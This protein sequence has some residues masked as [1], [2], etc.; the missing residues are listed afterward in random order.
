MPDTR[1]TERAVKFAGATL[2]VSTCVYVM[3]ELSV[4]GAQ[5]A[6]A[7]PFLLALGIPALVSG[8]LMLGARRVRPVRLGL[9]IVLAAMF[10][11][12]SPA[13]TLIGML[14]VVAGA[15]GGLAGRFQRGPL[16]VASL[17]GALVV[18][19]FTCQV[20]L[21]LG[22]VSAGAALLWIGV[23]YLVMQGSA[24]ALGLLGPRDTLTDMLNPFFRLLAESVNVITA[25]L[26]V[27][28][29]GGQAWLQTTMLLLTLLAAQMALIHLARTRGALGRSR[30]D[31]ASRLSELET[32][33]SIGSEIL[34]TLDPVRLCSILEREC[35]R[36][37]DW[38]D[39]YIGLSYQT[40]PHQGLVYRRTR[41]AEA[42]VAERL[43]GNG[44]LN[45]ISGERSGVRLDSIAKA[46]RS[47]LMVEVVDPE[48]RSAL[49]VPLLVGERAIG[50][51]SIQSRREG[52]FDHHQLSLL[53][54]IAQQAA[55]AME[56]AR[57]YRMATVDALT[58]FYNRDYFFQRL[59]DE[60]RRASRY[61]ARFSLLMMDLDGFKGLNDTHGH[62][63]GDQYLQAVGD[64][65]RAQLRQADMAGRFGGDE[66]CI[67]L[68]ETDFAGACAIAERIRE[69]ISRR[70][71]GVNGTTLRATA[72]IGVAAFPE[73]DAGAPR[74]LMKRA[75]AALYRAKRQGR[76][77]VAYYAA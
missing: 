41:G 50:L 35:R 15:G 53:T 60:Y 5:L 67:L 56:N 46:A 4:H 11:L 51:L 69:A 13:G 43:L 59:E 23:F 61:A 42:E 25:W 44:V 45:Y 22:T 62:I 12:P 3:A 70:A 55:A 74:D 68:P 58:G 40:T 65:I 76:D 72:S 24:V 54:T 66:F 33:H 36:V 28:L 20:L 31:L 57:H 1:S 37:F 14:A 16:A 63:A 38:D 64:T 17:G 8:H 2:L 30:H 32:L 34:T 21:P 75:D 7:L 39:F 49:I 18:T 71:I 73:H 10:L 48:S 6:A 47:A 29:L 27:G 19:E 9:G 52:A 77:C 26:L